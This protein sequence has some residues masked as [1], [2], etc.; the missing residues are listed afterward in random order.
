MK[1]DF[2]IPVFTKGEDD[3]LIKKYDRIFVITFLSDMSWKKLRVC[4]DGKLTNV[5]VPILQYNTSKKHQ[6]LTA[7]QF[8]LNP[9]KRFD[10]PRPTT[11]LTR[12]Q[13]SQIFSKGIMKSIDKNIL[14]VQ[15]EQSRD[16]LDNYNLIFIE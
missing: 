4:V 15:T 5:T 3:T 14:N 12:N 7:I 13:M 16:V 1:I 8:S 2:R 11:F 9:D 10:M 6:F